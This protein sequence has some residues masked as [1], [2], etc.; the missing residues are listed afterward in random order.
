MFHS[1]QTDNGENRVNVIAQLATGLV[2]ILKA[3]GSARERG[4]VGSRLKGGLSSHL[5]FPSNEAA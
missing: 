4:K 1:A 2:R 5:G 3:L